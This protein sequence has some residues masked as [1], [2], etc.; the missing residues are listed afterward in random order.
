MADTQRD[1][2]ALLALLADNTA[3]AISEQDL[4]DLLVS[5]LGGFGSITVQDGAAALVIGTTPVKLDKF[6]ANGPS[7]SVVPDH[8]ADSISTPVAG[9]Y[10]VTGSFSFSGTAARTVQLRLRKQVAE[11]DGIGCRAKINASGDT[12]SVSFC[13]LVTCAASDVL[14]VYAEAD[15]DATSMTLIDGS[16]VVKRAD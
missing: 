9:R 7:S 11:V 8:T 2:A 5:A 14:N 15:V 3:G 16:L 4:R 13:G 10:L 6:T 12:V 1:L